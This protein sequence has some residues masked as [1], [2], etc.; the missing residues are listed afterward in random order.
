MSLAL[1]CTLSQLILPLALL[2]ALTK[3]FR[4]VIKRANSPLAL[5][6]GPPGTSKIFPGRLFEFLSSDDIGS[7][8]E[9]WAKQYGLVFKIPTWLGGSHVILCDPKAVAHLYAKDGFTYLRSPL[10]KAFSRAFIGGT[11]TM[12][13]ADREEHRRFRRSMAPAFSISA[14]RTLTGI[15]YDSAYKVKSH[16]DALLESSDEVIIDVQNWSEVIAC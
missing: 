2:F 15:F 1:Q 6:K 5:L 4:I 14:L 11:I 12:T 3:L 7:L 10:N 9:V 16:W 8:C 13:T